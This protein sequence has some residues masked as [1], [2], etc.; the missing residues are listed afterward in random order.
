MQSE[1]VYTKKMLTTNTKSSDNWINYRLK[2]EHGYQVQMALEAII[3]TY[4]VVVI[5]NV[6]PRDGNINLT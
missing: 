3:R 1:Y 6:S 4:Q 2:I 5:F